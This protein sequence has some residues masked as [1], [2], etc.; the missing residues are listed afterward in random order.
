[1]KLFGGS[2]WGICP[3][4]KRQAGV[5]VLHSISCSVHLSGYLFLAL[6]VAFWYVNVSRRM[7][8]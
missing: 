8:A 5:D 3:G 1:M 6:D 2:V 7:L 4:K